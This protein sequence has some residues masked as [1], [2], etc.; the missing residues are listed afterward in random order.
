MPQSVVALRVSL[1]AKIYQDIEISGD[2]SLYKL[3]EVIN[4]V[5]GF[6]FDHAF[7]FYDNKKNPTSQKSFMSSSRTWVRILRRDQRVSKNPR[8]PTPLIARA[9]V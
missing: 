8:W 4:N 6:D 9:R 3:A 1:D 5:L 7:G 2:A